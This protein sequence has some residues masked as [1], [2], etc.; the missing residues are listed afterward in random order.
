[1]GDLGKSYE[2]A[3]VEPR[4]GEFRSL[5]PYHPAFPRFR[6][7]AAEVYRSTPAAW[8]RRTKI[9]QFTRPRFQKSGN[10]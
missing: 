1:M 6:P 10:T 3:I 7:E 2:T 8:A 5:S 9:T 4:F